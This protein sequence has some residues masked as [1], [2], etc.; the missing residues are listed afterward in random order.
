[1]KVIAKVFSHKPQIS[2]KERTAECP[3][4]RSLMVQTGRRAPGWGWGNEGFCFPLNS[5]SK[6][7]HS[8]PQSQLA[9]S[10]EEFVFKFS[11]T[12]HIY[13]SPELEDHSDVL[14]SLFRLLASIWIKQHRSHPQHP[15]CLAEPPVKWEESPCT[16]AA[17]ALGHLQAVRREHAADLNL[18][19][20]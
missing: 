20:C 8:Q 1:M 18:G 4:L 9:L 19:P 10:P 2:E 6:T 7:T 15:L 17:Q 12:A 14:Q 11:R 16:W 13:L 5:G 3:L